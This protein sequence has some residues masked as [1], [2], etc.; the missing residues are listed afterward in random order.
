MTKVAWDNGMYPNN[1]SKAA[2][3]DAVK[4]IQGKALWLSVSLPLQRFD[5]RLH[6]L[7]A[8]TTDLYEWE[9]HQTVDEPCSLTIALTLLHDYLK[10]QSQPM[11]LL[12]HGMSGV[13]GLLY[14][15]RYPER[16]ASLTLLSV[17]ANPT[18]T[19]HS[20][21]YALRNLLPC[22][23]QMVLMQVARL[24]LGAYPSSV[25]QAVATMLEQDL[26]ECL[27]LH[28]LAN[29]KNLPSRPLQVPLLVCQGQQDVI[30]DPH[31]QIQWRQWMKEGDRLWQCPAGRHF[32]HYDYPQLV[33][34]IITDYWKQLQ[35]QPLP[36]LAQAS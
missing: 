36:M 20:H 25:L 27:T 23:R 4:N 19:W 5:R 17:G 8:N 31:T 13:L 30:L 28:S 35:S 14:A 22:S 34:H 26:D 32:F 10:Q 16:V 18:V 9:Y 12:G 29:R 21:Y 7:L 1:T 6:S 3:P 2:E 24:L 11:H 15:S 33:A